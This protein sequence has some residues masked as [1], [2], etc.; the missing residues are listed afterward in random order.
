MERARRAR[1]A[2]RAVCRALLAEA[3]DG[4]GAMR[5][6]PALVG[7]ITP[8]QLLERWLDTDQ[9]TV[10]LVGEIHRVVV[11]LAAATT[12]TRPGATGLSGSIEC[13]YVENEARGVGVGTA[14]MDA[15]MAWCARQGCRDVDALALPG[16]RATKQRLEAQGFTARLLTLTRQMG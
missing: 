6:G 2:D 8:E 13:C 11:G 15:L 4:A 5:G 10:L 3:I 16:D 9:A 7:V 14:L 12:F 1:K